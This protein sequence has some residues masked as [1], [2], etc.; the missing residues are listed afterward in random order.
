MPGSFQVQQGQIKVYNS[1]NQAI[2]NSVVYGNVIFATS[3]PMFYA[4]YTTQSQ[5]HIFSS[6]STQAIKQGLTLDGVCMVSGN[7]CQ[8]DQIQSLGN[9]RL[10][11]IT[12]KGNV[13]VYKIKDI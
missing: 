2:S 12:L 13:Q 4:L 7:D 5:L 9:G 10:C 11:V 3:N 8:S 6:R 1:Q